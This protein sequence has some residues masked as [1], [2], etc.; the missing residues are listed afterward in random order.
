MQA[1]LDLRRLYWA[2]PITIAVAV[3]A[4]LIVQVIA[5]AVLSPLRQFAQMLDSREPTVSTIFMVSAAVLVFAIVGRVADDP[6]RTYRKIALVV[7]VLTFIPNIWLARS[8]IPGTGW[9][10]AIA[11]ML[12]HVAAW[13]VTVT[14]LPRLATV[15]TNPL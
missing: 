1:P 12:M 13:A 11:L 14:L 7:L 15:P 10:L 5:V 8:S 9:P 3:V 4:V 6:I 2:G